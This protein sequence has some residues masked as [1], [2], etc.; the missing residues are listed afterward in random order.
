MNLTPKLIIKI[1]V[2]IIV[3]FLGLPLLA[4]SWFTIDEG[5]RGVVLTN[6]RVTKSS[7]EP[8]FNLMKP[9]IEEVK[10]ID[11]KTRKVVYAFTANT[12]DQQVAHVQ[13]SV[14]YRTDPIRAG[15]I[16][17]T[18][19][20]VEALEDRVITPQVR[21]VSPNVFGSYNAEA[22]IQQRASLNADLELAVKEAVVGPLFLETVQ[23]ETFDL[24]EAYK[25]SI[26]QRMLAEV[27]VQTRRQDLER[28]RVQAEIVNTQADAE[29]YRLRSIGQAEA[30]AINARGQA[31]RDNPDLVALVQAEKWNGVLPTTMPP[32]GT[33]PIINVN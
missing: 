25:N 1:V 7:V 22:S 10:K 23:L 15:E 19:G 14:T 2:G 21:S 12:R 13:I 5:E 11:V 31:L 26:E 32:M 3:F 33:L 17:S 28:E 8:G 27:A 9:Y 20:T 6:G 4:G 24:S 29:A 30:D 18:Y 16:Y